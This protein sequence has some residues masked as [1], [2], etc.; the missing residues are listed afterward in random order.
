[1]RCKTVHLFLY[2]LEEKFNITAIERI[3]LV[4]IE[5]KEYGVNEVHPVYYLNGVLIQ[6]QND[7]HLTP[8]E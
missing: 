8:L 6:H 3:L 5:Y 4:S 1:M 7:S 2:F